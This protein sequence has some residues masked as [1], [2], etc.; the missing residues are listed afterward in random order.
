MCLLNAGVELHISPQVEF[1]GDELD[2]LERF[3][4]RCKVLG[5]VPFIEEFLRE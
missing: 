3:S 5:P 4:L 2:I 1:L